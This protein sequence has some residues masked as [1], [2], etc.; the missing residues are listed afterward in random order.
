MGIGLGKRMKIT[1]GGFRKRG[2]R[3]TGYSY[4]KKMRRRGE[5]SLRLRRNEDDAEGI[6][7]R[8]RGKRTKKRLRRA[9]VKN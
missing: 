2:W 1:R 9:G 8:E 6:I 4:G 7:G 5:M 3:K